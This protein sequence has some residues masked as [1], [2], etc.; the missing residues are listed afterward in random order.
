[1]GA[2]MSEKHLDGSAVRGVGIGKGGSD[3]DAA[4]LAATN[5]GGGGLAQRLQLSF[6]AE[7]LANMDT[8]S[9]SDPFVIF[10]KL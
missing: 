1:M 7:N 10:Y 5:F 4:V 6:A 8:F 9:K 3:I 2:C